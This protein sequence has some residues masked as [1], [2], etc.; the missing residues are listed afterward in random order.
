MLKEIILYSQGLPVLTILTAFFGVFVIVWAKNK[1]D[2]TESQRQERISSL[3]KFLAKNTDSPVDRPN[4]RARRKAMESIENRFS[5]IRR[6]SLFVLILIWMIALFF[7]YMGS[8]PAT[9]ISVFAASIGVVVGIMARPLIENTIAGMVISFSQPFR[10]NDTV[11]V[12]GH[13][14]TIEDITT[15]HT[16]L[17]LWNW[18]RVIFPN[19]MMLSQKVINYTKTDLYQWVNIEF[20]VSYDCDLDNVERLVKRAVV[21]SNHF[22]DY[23]DPR[24]WVISMD[25]RNFKCWVVAWAENPPSAWELGHEVRSKIIKVFHKHEIKASKVELSLSP[26]AIEQPQLK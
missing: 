26:E 24:F 2:D 12:D 15:I 7:P 11:I 18:K 6:I 5:I 23:E 1:I 9:Y 3:D 8:I 4:R 21:N 14:G 16:V 17:K 22:A 25:E 13:Y 19:S 10:V 20:L